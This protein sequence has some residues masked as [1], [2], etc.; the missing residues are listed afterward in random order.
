MKNSIQLMILTLFTLVFVS[1][2]NMTIGFEED[3]PL[4]NG[5]IIDTREDVKSE[6]TQEVT[7][8]KTE[9]EAKIESTKKE[10][11]TIFSYE[12]DDD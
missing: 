2:S 9:S 11:E 3:S 8:E 4:Y 12:R 7:Q 6:E 1:C 10:D 5:P